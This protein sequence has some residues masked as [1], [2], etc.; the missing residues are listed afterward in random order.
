MT[1]PIGLRIPGETVRET[2][3]PEFAAWCKSTGFDAIDLGGPN[4]DAAKTVRDAGLQLGTVDLS[5]TS[6]LLSPDAA[7]R[8]RA[9]ETVANTLGVIHALGGDRAFLVLFPKNA[10]QSRRESFENWKQSFPAVVAEAERLNIRLALEGWPGPNNSALGVTPET[11]RVMFAAVPSAHFG[12]NYDPS[13]LARVGVD[14]LRFLDEFIGRIVHAHGKDTAM[15]DEGRYRYGTLG[16]TLDRAPDFGSG[17]WRYC[18]P[19]EGVVNWAA[20]CGR[21]HRAGYTG[22][23]SLELEDFR[24]NGTADGAKRGLTR[25]REFLAP[26]L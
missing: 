18:I 2:S 1:I 21:L 23:V 14:Y 12:L 25:A 5:G 17:D 8:G 11:L 3:L 16:T 6:D 7:E 13:H 4:A 26:Y 22:M 24:Y 10:G 15:D 9:V 20:V 19:G